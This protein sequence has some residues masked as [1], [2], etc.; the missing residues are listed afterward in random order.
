MPD[1]T[2]SS[3]PWRQ[4]RNSAADEKGGIHDDTTAKNLGF[5]GGTI[6][7]SVSMEQFTPLLVRYF[8]ETWWTTGGM[9]V[10]LTQPVFDNEPVRCNLKPVKENKVQIW[11]E[12]KAGNVVVEGTA[13]LGDDP[14]SEINARLLDNQPH[15][16]LR[17]LA[18]VVIDTPSELCPV[19]ISDEEIDARLRVITEPMDCYASADQ[20]GERVAPIAPYVHAFRGV[21]PHIV[22]VRGP[23][24]GMFGA[25][26][27]QYLAGPVLANTDYETSGQVIA[28]S[29]SPKTEIVWYTATLTATDTGQAVARMTKMDR[30]L[31]SASPLWS[32]SE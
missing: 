2:I 30:L 22:P 3:G 28:L 8:G 15:P 29:A 18:D 25:I 9:S 10:F 4:P 13:S 6:P 26:E 7:G 17:M 24:V 1:N 21:E 31:K 27:V 20:F 16:E 11:M 14:E 12:N 5:Q 23:Y 19:R 32:E